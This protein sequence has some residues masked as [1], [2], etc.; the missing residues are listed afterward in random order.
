MKILYDKAVNV[1]WYIDETGSSYAY[2][3]RNKL[4]RNKVNTVHSRGYVYVRTTNRNHQVH[5]L[6]ANAFI[7]RHNNEPCVNHIDGNKQNNH[8]N[9]LEWCTYK[10]NAQHA[11]A[12]GLT[13]KYKKNEG[14]VKYSNEVCKNV[15]DLIKNGMTYKNAGLEYGMP[16]STVAHL[17]RGS[18]RLI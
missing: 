15:L 16:Y 5:R 17:V 4:W 7:P 2:D 8:V 12:L 18:R 11:I 6:V 9:N 13:T 3:T 10:E 14:N 1:E